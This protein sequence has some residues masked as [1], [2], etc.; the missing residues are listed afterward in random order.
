MGKLVAPAAINHQ[1]QHRKSTSAAGSLD[2]DDRTSSGL[3]SSIYD[4]EI[5]KSRAAAE[6]CVISVNHSRVVV[7]VYST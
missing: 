5:I 3:P 7:S 2:Q 6:L 4:V 1:H